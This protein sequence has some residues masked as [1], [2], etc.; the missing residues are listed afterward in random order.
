MQE[1]QTPLEG[2]R[3]SQATPPTRTGDTVPTSAVTPHEARTMATAP[4][5]FIVLAVIVAVI[6]AVILFALK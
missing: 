6:V 2:N 4:V 3:E 1:R 5:G